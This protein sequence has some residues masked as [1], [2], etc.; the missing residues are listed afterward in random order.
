MSMKRII[1]II[2]NFLYRK[3]GIVTS[4]RKERWYRD[5]VKIQAE[6]DAEHSKP[7]W[8]HWIFS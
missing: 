8:G 3:L 5:A 1:S 4:S 6:L 2:D 7:V